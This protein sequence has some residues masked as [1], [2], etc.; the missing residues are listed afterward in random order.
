MLKFYV[1]SVCDLNSNN[2]YGGHSYL[3]HEGGN[4]YCFVHFYTCKCLQKCLAQRRI[5]VDPQQNLLNE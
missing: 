3:Q 2:E 5:T 4:C 1:V